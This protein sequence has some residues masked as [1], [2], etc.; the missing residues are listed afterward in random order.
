MYNKIFLSNGMEAQE[1]IYHEFPVEE[2]NDNPLIKAL[3]LLIDKRM[4][5]KNLMINPKIKEEE[6][7]LDS[8]YR[9]HIVQRLYKLFQPVPIHI[10]IWNMLFTL[11]M[12]GYL[13]RNPFD[14]KYK[15]YIN[16]RGKNIINRNYEINN[17]LNFRTTASCATIIGISGMGKTT[18]VNRVLSNLPQIIVHNKYN[19]HQFTQIQLT[20]LKLET[21]HNSSLKALCLQYF[22]KIDELLGTNNFKKYV[23]RNL[24]V[25][26]M[27]PLM[28]QVAQNIGLGM[29]VIDEIQHLRNRGGEQIMNFFVTLINSFGIP[30][31]IIGTPASYRLFQNEF[32]IAR[33]ITGNGEII[34]NNM[35]NDD[36]FKLFL[37]GI[38]K[39]QWTKKPVSLSKEVIDIIYE[40]TQG[41]SDLVVK[42]FINS[43]IRAINGGSEKITVKLIKSVAKEQFK[44]MRP[45]INAM[46]SGNPYKIQQ[47]ED[48]KTILINEDYKFET[49]DETFKKNMDMNKD[50]NIEKESRGENNTKEKSSNKL[51]EDDLRY[52]VLQEKDLSCYKVL[53]DNHY[54]DDLSFWEEGV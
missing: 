7:L 36:E 5:I 8:P 54:I 37:N 33:R 50:K 52:L 30:L 46:K 24:S 49:K 42:L 4:I 10:D 44:L 34:W 13:A 51:R 32:R 39:Y 20:W 26:A 1:A 11:I 9:L 12:Q 3:P 47:F 48:I 25:D 40:E 45:M 23:S 31:V 16:E 22:M 27:L 15:S 19:N 41:V 17:N 53:E 43:Q 14:K 18:T 28:G 29:L 38:W 21:P 6:R 35:K 2:Y